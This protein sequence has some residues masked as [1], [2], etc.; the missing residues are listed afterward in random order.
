MDLWKKF[1]GMA[2]M[3]IVGLCVGAAQVHADSITLFNTGIAADGSLAAGGSVDLHYTLISSADPSFPGPNA[4]VADPIAIGSWVANGPSSQWISPSANQLCCPPGSGNPVGDYTYRTTFDLT[5]LDPGSALITGNWATDNAGVDIL[6]NGISTGQTTGIADFGFFTSFS[7]ST[8]F[9]SGLNTLDFVTNNACCATG[10]PTGL[11]VELS[12]T[13]TS[14]A[15]VPEPSS[16]LLF[17][18]GLAGLRL[19]GRK[20]LRPVA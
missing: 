8:G 16:L 5:G 3:A 18:F 19:W 15:A 2:V 20:R 11:R 1:L 14:V 9:V 10:N 6:I 4:I 17:G 13:A 12:G 7:I